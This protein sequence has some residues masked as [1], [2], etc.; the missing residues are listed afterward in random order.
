[1]EQ[2]AIHCHKCDSDIPSSEYSSHNCYYQKKIKGLEALIKKI[3]EDNDNIRNQNEEIK[4]LL[5]ELEKQTVSSLDDMTNAVI[6]LKEKLGI[7]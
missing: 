4:I 7:K 6:P 2:D 5:E 3:N 1:M